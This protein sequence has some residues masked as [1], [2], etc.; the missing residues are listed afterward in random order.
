MKRFVTIAV[1]VLL[2]GSAAGGAYL[3]ATVPVKL[4]GPDQ[5]QLGP[6][7]P[8]ARFQTTLTFRNDSWRS[9]RIEDV[10]FC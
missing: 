10:Y 3:W 6:R 7:P 4:S 8:E 2:A 5:V 1:L 9:V